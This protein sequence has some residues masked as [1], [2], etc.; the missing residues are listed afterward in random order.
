MNGGA[1]EESSAELRPA[2]SPVLP[3]ARFSAPSA[4]IGNYVVAKCHSPATTK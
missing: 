1:F 3:P 4:M 2:V